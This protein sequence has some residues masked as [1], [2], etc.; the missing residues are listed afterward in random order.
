VANSYPP[1]RVYLHEQIVARVPEVE[2][3]SLAT[4][5]NS[6][7]RW[8]GLHPPAAI[9]PV[10][11]SHGE[12][13]NEQ[14]VLRYSLR[15]W[16]KGG[17]IIRWLKEHDVRA[18]LV[19]G[20]GDMGRMRIIR[21]CNRRGIPCFLTGDFNIRSDNHR[22]LKR[23]LKQRV[24]NRGVGWSYGLM[25]CGELG[26]KLLERYGGHGKPAFMFPFVPDIQLFENTPA[27]AVEQLRE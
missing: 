5:S 7:Q 20:C 4:H 15:E 17:R 18:V 6:Y 2:L 19:Q 24:Y 23:W 9:R 10:N 26:L 8:R 11:F 3:W 13:S 1:Y 25:P 14:P 27:E 21:W 16:R 22:P 12:P